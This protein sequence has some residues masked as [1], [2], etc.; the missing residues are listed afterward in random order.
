MGLLL[1]SVRD[2][3]I[4]MLDP[5][6][7]VATWNAGAERIKGYSADEIVGTHFSRFYTR[8]DIERGEP[9]R[10]LEVAADRGAYEI[11]GWRVRKDGSWFWATVLIT[12]LRGD[13][14]VLRGYAK[15]TR[16]VT[17][18][19]RLHFLGDASVVL[20]G[21]LDYEATLRKVAELT[22]PFIADW[23]AVQIVENDRLRILAVAHGDSSKVELA[24]ELDRKY[25][26]DPS[27]PR[28][29]GRSFAAGSRNSTA[30]SRTRRSSVSHVTASTSPCF[31]R[32]A[33]PPGC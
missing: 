29:P 8:D 15:V 27:A 22:I 20:S 7:R 13:S 24:K 23:C 17:E 30:R 28:G 6:G 1:K 32:S 3:A 19:H 26:A 31:E 10:E 33:S 11:E 5:N 18:R 21:S 4:F 25:P 9:E 2:Y 14:G 12:A 16:D